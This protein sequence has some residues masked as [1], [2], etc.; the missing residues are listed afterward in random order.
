MLNENKG[1]EMIKILQYLQRYIPTKDIPSQHESSF[2][3]LQHALLL[4]GDQ[5]TVARIRGAQI[6]M[7]NGSNAVK[8]L[9]GFIPVIQDWHAKVVLLEVW[10]LKYVT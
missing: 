9:E 2:D 3:V 6:A 10:Y 1:D 8:S 4:G 5:L 7:C